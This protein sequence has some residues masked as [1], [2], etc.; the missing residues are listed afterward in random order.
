VAFARFDLPQVQDDVRDD[1][2]AQDFEVRPVEDIGQRCVRGVQIVA[3]R[4]GIL[5]PQLVSRGDERPVLLL[6]E[7]VVPIVEGP[8]KK[9]FEWHISPARP[10]R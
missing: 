6:G 8:R 10:P 2:P 1:G 4:F 5:P 9:E 7:Q 3:R